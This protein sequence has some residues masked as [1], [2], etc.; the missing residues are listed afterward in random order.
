[1]KCCVLAGQ[2]PLVTTARNACL[3]LLTVPIDCAVRTSN[4]VDKEQ[5][6]CATESLSYLYVFVYLTTIQSQLNTVMTAVVAQL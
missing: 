5:N 1:M 2:V 3:S 6:E 4:A